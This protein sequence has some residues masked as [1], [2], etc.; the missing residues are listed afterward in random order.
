MQVS[1]SDAASFGQQSTS[2]AALLPCSTG[3]RSRHRGNSH[4]PTRHAQ[5]VLNIPLHLQ[6]SGSVIAERPRD[7][8]C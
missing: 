6:I 3:R 1:W 5:S 2:S 4:R 8:L 7:A